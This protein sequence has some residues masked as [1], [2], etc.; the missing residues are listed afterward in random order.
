MFAKMLGVKRPPESAP[1]P[2]PAA[3]PAAAPQGEPSVSSEPAH[4]DDL[5]VQ[6]LVVEEMAV[7]K[8][9]LEESYSRLAAEKAALSGKVADLVAANTA[10]ECE[11]LCAEAR[12]SVLADELAAANAENAELRSALDELEEKLARMNRRLVAL[13]RPGWFAKPPVDGDS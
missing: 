8:V 12:A 4:V 13:R 7:E 2:H 10:R 6:A 3:R 11:R 9:A 1:A 5:E